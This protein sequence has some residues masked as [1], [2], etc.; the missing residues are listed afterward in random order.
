MH[1]RLITITPAVLAALFAGC[2][3][4]KAPEEAR[5]PQQTDWLGSAEPFSESTKGNALCEEQRAFP[6]SF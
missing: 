3:Q 2:Q 4:R 1:T 5:A 6:V